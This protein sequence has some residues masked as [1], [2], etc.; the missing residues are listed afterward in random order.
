MKNRRYILLVLPTLLF[1]TMAVAQRS[2]YN[3][4]NYIVIQGGITQYD[5]L[6]DTF[7][8]TSDTG[9]AAGLETMVNVPHKWYDVS[10]GIL[11]SDNTLNILAESSGSSSPREMLPYKVSAAQF[12]T[13]LHA[14]ILKDNLT[15]D[16]GP[17]VQANSKLVLQNTNKAD[18]LIAGHDALY[19]KDIEDISKFNINGLVGITTGFKHFRLSAQYQYGFTNTLSKLNDLNTNTTFK[20][21]QSQWVFTA[22]VL[23]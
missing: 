8:T 20:G 16:F 10:F 13:C 5:I 18:Y 19:A 11:F 2:H 23:F 7:E 15:I 12:I 3:I 6:T 22:M 21:N 9:W 1:V 17:V 4:R 14:K